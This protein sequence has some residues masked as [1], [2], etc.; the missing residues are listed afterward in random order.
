VVTKYCLCDELSVV[1]MVAFFDR[2]PVQSKVH[3]CHQRTSVSRVHKSNKAKDR[4][5][6]TTDVG[7]LMGVHRGTC[8]GRL[9]SCRRAI[10]CYREQL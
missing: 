6:G 5:R 3:A 9:S 4:S 10:Y 2:R 8:D 1:V 7:P